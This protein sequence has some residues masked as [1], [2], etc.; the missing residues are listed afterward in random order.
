VV[1]FER[2]KE[3][4][5]RGKSPRTAISLGY[6]K[7]FKAILD[8]NLTT[9]ITAFILFALSSGSVRGFA[10]L[11]AL[12]VL[13]SMFTAVAVTRAL[14]GVLSD[15]GVKLSAPMV[16][17]LKASIETERPAKV[18][19]AGAGNTLVA[20]FEKVDFVGR[21]RIWFAISG[22]FL[23]LCLGAIA[24]GGFNLGI[25]FTGGSKFTA[26]SVEGEPEPG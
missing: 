11:L 10:V 26:S 22:V 24:L 7:G 13:L 19:K 17:V 1:I 23:L 20:V 12:G 16:G 14:L 4:I 3:E 5:R 8:G 9:L 6:Q 15:R 18:S 2:I 21:W 25:D